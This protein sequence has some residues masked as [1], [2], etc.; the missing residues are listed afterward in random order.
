MGDAGQTWTQC[1]E[2]VCGGRYC[3]SGWDLNS[4]GPH[5]YKVGREGEKTPQETKD[6]SNLI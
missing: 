1:R 6:L 5:P 2:C 4:A 3:A